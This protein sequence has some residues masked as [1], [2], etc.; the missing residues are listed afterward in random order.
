MSVTSSQK[1]FFLFIAVFINKLIV[2]GFKSFATSL[3]SHNLSYILKQSHK[4][5][6]KI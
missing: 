6:F 5:F 2:Q 1:E 3:F 4:Y